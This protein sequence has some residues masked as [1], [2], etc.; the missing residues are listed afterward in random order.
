MIAA[1]LVGAAWGSTPVVV[2]DLEQD[3][4]EWISTGE[5]GQWTWGAV[6]AGP[7]SGF[8]GSNAWA[9]GREAVYLNDS[10]ELLE[11][12]LPSLEPVV[13]PMLSFHHWYAFGPGDIGYVEIDEGGGWH[14]LAPVYGYPT[15]AGWAESSAGW[16]LASFELPPSTLRLRLVFAA[17]VS[18][19]GVGWFVDQV[20]LW[21][22]DVT[23][24]QVNELESLPDTESLE[25]PYVVHATVVD[26]TRVDGVTISFVTSAGDSGVV[27]MV[28]TDAT[29]WEGEIPVQSVGTMVDYHIV[30]TDGANTTRAPVLG[31]NTFRVYLPAPTDLAGPAGRVVAQKAVLTWEAPV[32]IHRVQHY[33]VVRSDVIEVITLDTEAVVAVTGTYDTFTVRAIY[34]EGEGDASDPCSIHG[35]QPSL[36]EIEPAEGYP[37]DRLRVLVTGQDAIFATGEVFASFG[38]DAVVESITVRDVDRFVAELRLVDNAAAGSWTVT[39]ETAAGI[40]QLPAAFTML[41]DADRPRILSLEPDEI[42][43]GEADT[44]RISLSRPPAAVPVV[45]LGEGVIVQSV[46]VEGTDVVVVISAA[47]NAPIG[48][49]AVTVDDGVRVLEGGSFEVRDWT[50]SP[51]QACSTGGSAATG[52]AGIGAALLA[53]IRSRRRGSAP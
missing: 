5:L 20:G 22:G 52:T 49:H 2:W 39:V 9:I 31:E 40:L 16:Q 12:P 43:Q 25:T 51:I 41:D 45:A 29:S 35:V 34:D 53:V 46:S 1:L 27:A 10:L 17:D 7:G 14:T 33:E 37:G 21:D 47:S 24:P 38:D 19:V 42:T 26:D 15:T 50:A 36:R 13:R 30:A 11:V 23:G 44:V 8:D 28:A 32:S 6:A 4:G 18:G 48:A 3:D